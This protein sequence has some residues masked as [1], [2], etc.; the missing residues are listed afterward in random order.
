MFRS[1]T[2]DPDINQIGMGTELFRLDRI[3]VDLNLTQLDPFAKP[4]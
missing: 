4:T 3:W 1:G 2:D